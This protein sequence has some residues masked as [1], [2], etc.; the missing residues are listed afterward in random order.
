MDGSGK[1]I[2]GCLFEWMY[3]R[4]MPA[5]DL[6][7]F[8]RPVSGPMK[9][10]SSVRVCIIVPNFGFRRRAGWLKSDDKVAVEGK[11]IDLVSRLPFKHRPIS[12][13]WLFCPL[14]HHCIP[15]FQVFL[16]SGG[17]LLPFTY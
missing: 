6:R 7:G 12:S 4:S 3:T 8:F 11:E 16:F 1:L 13:V 15:K 10:C 9:M 17:I 2:G 5:P 14:N